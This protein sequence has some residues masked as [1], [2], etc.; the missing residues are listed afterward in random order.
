MS[1]KFPVPVLEIFHIYDIPERFFTDRCNA[2]YF[3]KI[4]EKFVDMDSVDP[5]ESFILPH[6]HDKLHV[7]LNYF[8][9]GTISNSSKYSGQEGRKMIIHGLFALM[10]TC[11]DYKIDDIN[12]GINSGIE[13]L[14]TYKSNKFFENLPVHESFVGKWIEENLDIDKICWFLENLRKP[15]EDN[16]NNINPIDIETLYLLR[17]TINYSPLYCISFYPKE[18]Q[19]IQNYSLALTLISY[20]GATNLNKIHEC[21]NTYFRSPLLHEPYTLFTKK[22]IEIYN[23]SKM[24]NDNI[25]NDD[26][27]KYINEYLNNH[28]SSEDFDIM[29]AKNPLP[30][31][32]QMNIY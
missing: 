4:C 24:N 19:E 14:K 12:V 23:T 18:L 15:Y 21:F 31:N 22:M 5:S 29:K 10:Y 11:W 7:M 32:D 27:I 26:S 25:L 1:L 16:F 2:A 13:Q 20:Y 3:N 30:I 28:M 8:I 6:M 9:Q 17:D